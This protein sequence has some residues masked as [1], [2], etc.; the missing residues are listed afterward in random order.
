MTNINMDKKVILNVSGKLFVTTYQTCCKSQFL[1]AKLDRW[2]NT[3][4]PIFLD[5]SPIVFK[6]VLSYM[7]N[8]N[9][10]FPPEYSYELDYFA[11]DYDFHELVTK[12]SC[13]Y[14]LSTKSDRFYDKLCDIY[15]VLKPES[16]H[17]ERKVLCWL[18]THM[19]NIKD[20]GW[21]QSKDAQVNQEVLTSVGT[22]V[23]I[24]RVDKCT[25]ET[26]KMVTINNLTVTHGHPIYFNDE[27]KR[28]REI[29]NVH[30]MKD[31]TY[32]NFV[33]ESQHD[34]VIKNENTHDTL[35]VA[36]LGKFPNNWRKD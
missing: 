33:L 27:W 31:V 21:I 11:I 1:R 29:G 24:Q 10:P 26:K 12:M 28:A 23:K 32:M 19:V 7:Q 34:I 18:E 6:H 8:P 14:I 2:N 17:E 4:E 15:D 20:L 9:Y 5:N 13:H 16:F 30:V 36:T 22:Y 3:D 25:S 35:I